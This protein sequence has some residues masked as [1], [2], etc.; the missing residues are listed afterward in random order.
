MGNKLARALW[1]LVVV[2]FVALQVY[3]F[4]DGNYYDLITGVLTVAVLLGMIWVYF[5]IRGRR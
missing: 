1:L 3:H 5:L 4:V 2:L